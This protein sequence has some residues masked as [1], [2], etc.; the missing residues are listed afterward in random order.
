MCL[1]KYPVNITLFY[2]NK[3]TTESGDVDVVTLK[4]FESL[5]SG[6]SW[7][8]ILIGLLSVFTVILL[9]YIKKRNKE[10]VYK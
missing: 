4:E 8:Y 10:N 9:V 2:S 6:F 1:G 5:N 7:A 3:T